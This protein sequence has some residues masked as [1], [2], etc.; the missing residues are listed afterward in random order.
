M[1][2]YRQAGGRNTRALVAALLAGVLLGGLV[3]FLIGHGSADQPSAAELVAD[4]RAELQ[5]AA[6]GLEL[7]AI[8]Y[9][10]AVKGGKVVAETEYQATVD[11]VSRVDD[12]LT[13]SAE[14][15]RAIDP[16]GYAAATAAVGRL[17]NAVDAI[18][19]PTRVE[20]LARTAGEKVG[21]LSGGSK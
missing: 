21:V 18:E 5:P 14:D 9:R 16:A 1:S 11:A 12:T 10:G 15:M 8:E 17:A 13:A 4:A 3:G 19:P 7:V 6:D 2:L 20:A